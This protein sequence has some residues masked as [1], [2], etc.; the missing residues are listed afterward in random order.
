MLGSLSD[1]L[2]GLGH[3]AE[4]D[5]SKH[6]AGG[7]EAVKLGHDLNSDL[8]FRGDRL[9]DHLGSLVHRGEGHRGQQHRRQHQGIKLGHCSCSAWGGPLASLR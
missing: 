4:S 9:G 5:R 3:H 2:R 6:G 7:D 8:V 1:D